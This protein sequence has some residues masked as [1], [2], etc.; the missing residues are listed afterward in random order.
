MKTFQHA[1]VVFLQALYAEVMAYG[2]AAALYI[3]ICLQNLDDCRIW[4]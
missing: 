2:V 4:S 1:S 3:L